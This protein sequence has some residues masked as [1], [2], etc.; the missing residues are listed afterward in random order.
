MQRVV[1]VVELATSK[2]KEGGR[3][4][5]VEEMP[6]DNKFHSQYTQVV[7]AGHP[8]R[9]VFVYDHLFNLLSM[10]GYSNVQLTG[11]IEETYPLASYLGSEEAVAA[12]KAVLDALD[13]E[14][15]E[16]FGYNPAEGTFVTNYAILVGT[17]KGV[18]KEE[19]KRKVRYYTGDEDA[20]AAQ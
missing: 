18:A 17:K 16:I 15:R 13:D 2:L 14:T 11:S 9:N 19:K 6:P 7:R 3:F 1:D 20:A 12:A 4:V 5:I 10:R 8:E